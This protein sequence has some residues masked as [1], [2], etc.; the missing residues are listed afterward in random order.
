MG[1]R[2]NVF[3]AVLGFAIAI[4]VGTVG[5]AAQQAP[6]RIVLKS[7]ETVTLT[8]LFL[9]NELQVNVALLSTW[10]RFSHSCANDVSR[11]SCRMPADWR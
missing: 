8:K 9:D 2:T 5:A 11:A 6:Q 4:V 7:G 3:L 10:F 1:I